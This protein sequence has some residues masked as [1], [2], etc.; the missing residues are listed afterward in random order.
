MGV[1]AGA[2]RARGGGG[3]GGQWRRR[4]AAAERRARDPRL[5]RRAIFLSLA[6]LACLFVV[7]PGGLPELEAEAAVSAPTLHGAGLGWA[8]PPTCANFR[9]W[10]ITKPGL[11]RPAH[12]K[13]ATLLVAA[14]FACIV[15]I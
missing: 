15:H 9:L 8:G 3:A 10:P 6:L 13:T 1:G 14:Q 12:H 11:L 4:Y 2:A 7:S 5:R